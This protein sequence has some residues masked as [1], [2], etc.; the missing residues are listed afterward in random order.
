[1]DDYDLVE[2]LEDYDDDA[3]EED[4]WD[5]AEYDDDDDAV[6]ELLDAFA[7]EY[8][9]DDDAAERRRRRRRRQ[10]RQR[11]RQPRTARSRSY[12]RPR[13]SG[14]SVSQTQ[15]QASLAKVR[16]DV[17]KNASA[18]KTVGKQF[19]SHASRADRTNARQGTAIS[20]TRKD[21]AGLKKQVQ[22][23]Q[24]MAFLLPLMQQ[25]PKV[26]PIMDKVT[27]VSTSGVVSTTTE[28]VV[29]DVTVTSSS[30]NMLPLILMMGM[31]SGM[32]TGTGTGTSDSNMNMLL[33]VLAMQPGG[34]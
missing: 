27:S 12:V 30:D 7:A 10:R 15:L 28:E 16:S 5:L 24:Q 34:L 1:M 9:D 8:D 19:R 4:D 32:G 21:I 26:E 3:F 20:R 25:Q 33:L 11:Y 23:V 17:T 14:R 13:P 18:I 31:G 29:T 22:N 6:E 2:A